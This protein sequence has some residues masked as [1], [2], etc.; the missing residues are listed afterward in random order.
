MFTTLSIWSR[1]VGMK[2]ISL[3][4]IRCGR[5]GLTSRERIV[6]R[7]PRLHS[8]NRC[9]RMSTSRHYS[10]SSSKL[11]RCNHAGCELRAGF[12]WA[13]DRKPLYC[14]F[15]KGPA[16]EDVISPRCQH[17]GCGILRP[18]FGY[19][20][21]KGVM[22]LIHKLPGMENVTSPRCAHDGCNAIDPCFQSASGSRK[23]RFCNK[24]R[25]IDMIDITHR[26][27]GHEGC[28]VR[29]RYGYPFARGKLLDNLKLSG[30]N[31]QEYLK[32]QYNEN[33]ENKQ[34]MEIARFSARRTGLL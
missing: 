7:G 30:M 4:L 5:A 21:K 3:T 33:S 27:C 15:H 8:S 19:E 1:R 17:L 11:A 22:C 9:G 16:M 2:S 14:S 6:N 31:I 34:C 28:D 26:K 29:S 12:G 20:P 25:T 24:H 10:S 13:K 32:C 18:V 23:R